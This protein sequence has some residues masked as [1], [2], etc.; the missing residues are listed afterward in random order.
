MFNRGLKSLLS[1]DPHIEIIDEKTDITEA[2]QSFPV[3]KPDVIIWSHKRVNEVTPQAL[4]DLLDRHPGL[5]LISLNLQNNEMCIYQA[6]R[7]PSSDPHTLIGAIKYPLMS[8]VDRRAW[9]IV[10]HLLGNEDGHQRP[11]GPDGDGHHHP[12]LSKGSGISTRMEEYFR[13]ANEAC[14]RAKKVC[15]AS[16]QIQEK[17]KKAR[18]LRKG[19]MLV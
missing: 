12:S 6:A 18:L 9:A 19:Y 4:L 11:N 13:R 14:E 15:A 7:N 1:T 2:T 10:P 16:Q 3:L 8:E 5:K 17:T